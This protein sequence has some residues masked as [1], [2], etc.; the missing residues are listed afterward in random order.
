VSSDLREHGRGAPLHLAA[1]DESAVRWQR[2]ETEV[3]GDREVLAEGELLVHHPHSGG[4]GVARSPEARLAAEHEQPPRIGRVDA[5]EDLSERAL[6]G[7]VLAAEGVA[8]ARRDLERDVAERLHA[9]KALRD[10]LE[11]Y[12]GLVHASAARAQV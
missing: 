2:A 5:G 7:A 10:A 12:R 8:G 6:A 4:Q 1:V 11:P 9:G 3:L